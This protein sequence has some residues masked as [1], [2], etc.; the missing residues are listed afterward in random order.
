MNNRLGLGFGRPTL[1]VVD[2]NAVI[3]RAF[4]ALPPL[5][6]RQGEAV[7]AVYGFLRVLFKIIKEH[8]PTHLAVAFDAPGPT[9]RH[10]DF[11]EYKATRVKAPKE[12]Y[13]QIP[14]VK[15][16]LTA[17]GIS[18][19]EKEGFEA[20]DLIGTLVD[21]VDVEADKSIVTGDTDLLQLADEKTKVIL[22][23]RG[24]NQY[25]AFGPEEIREKYQGLSPGQ[26]IELKGLQGDSSDNLPGVPGVGEK[27]GRDLLR[28]F[29]SLEG[30]YQNLEEIPSGLREKLISH[31][32]QAFLSRR[33]GTIKRDVPLDGAL[34]KYRRKGYNKEEAI[35][36]LSRIGLESLAKNL[37]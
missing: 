7:G 11:P 37:P 27:T 9:F 8:D 26:L 32:E 12:L 5:T 3:H 19:L 4:H 10:R 29:G 31:K 34:E 22:L 1:F 16:F 30:V 21:G 35:S 13:Q 25:Q 20:D 17:L 14:L 23:Q 15:E 28:R 36:L 2:G 24:L 33:M 6:N 18:T